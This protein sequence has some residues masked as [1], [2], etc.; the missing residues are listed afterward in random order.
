M[1][2]VHDLTPKIL[3]NESFF[4]KIRQIKDFSEI[5]TIF[6]IFLFTIFLKVNHRCL[7]CTT[8]GNIAAKSADLAFKAA[9]LYVKHSRAEPNFFKNFTLHKKVIN[10]S[11][12]GHQSKRFFQPKFFCLRRAL[13]TI[14]FTRF[15]V[16]VKVKILRWK[17]K[18]FC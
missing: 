7:L 4:C 12:R 17:R 2:T 10:K 11:C 1:I 15:R 18:K 9:C 5:L 8:I 3:I 14:L 16:I 13:F 6:D